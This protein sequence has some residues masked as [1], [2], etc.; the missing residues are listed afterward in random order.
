MKKALGVLV[1]ALIFFIWQF[2][3]WAA[4]GV[5][6]GNLKHTPQQMEILA[7]LEGKLD[8]G[9]YFLP[10]VAPGSS[11]E[12]E[13]AFMKEHDGE[14]WAVISYHKS[15]DSSMGM[16]MLRGFATDLVI[17]FLLFWLLSQMLGMSVTKGA[18]VAV[19]IGILGYLSIRYMN[20]IWF[21]T[22]TIPDLIDAIVPWALSGVWLGWWLPKGK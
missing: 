9:T 6:E 13:E 14:A 12:Q 19:V 2:L 1:P 20:S 5:H 17:G 15:F 3:S 21:E 16:N 4:L 18:T 22:N 8:D 11:R 7:S 10:K